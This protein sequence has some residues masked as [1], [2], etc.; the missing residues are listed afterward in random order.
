MSRFARNSVFGTIAGVLGA[1]GSVA[2]NVI[3]ARC[4][5]VEQTGV[6]AF[7]VWTAMLAAAVADLGVQATL[8][9]YLPELLAA[10]REDQA[11]QLG[12]V[13]IR[14]LAISSALIFVAFVIYAQWEQRWRGMP[15]EETAIWGL[16][17]LCCVLQ[18]YA[19]FTYGVLRGLQRFDD[20]ARITAISAVCQ[21][22]GVAV[23]SV[24]FGTLGAL[25]GYCLG[26]VMPAVLSARYRGA[27]RGLSPET[28]A[29]IKRYALY[30]WATTL[31][32]TFVW[33]RS[34]LF[35]LQ[36]STG[37]IAVGL[38]TVSVTLANVAAQAPM[39]LTAGLLPYFAQTHGRRAV[40]EAAEAYAM[41]T[42]VLSFLVFPACCG[43]V[44]L[45][46]TVL[47]LVFGKAFGGAVPAASVLVL[48][49]GVSTATSVGTSLLLAMDRSDV[50]FGVGL[51]LAVLAVI[52]GLTVIPA[53][54]LMGAALTRAVLQI[55]GVI[56]GTVF[57]SRRMHFS[58]PM[59]GFLKIMLAA[60]LSGLATRGCLYL[61]PG[62]SL[63][64]FPI[65]VGIIVYALAV[66]VLGALHPADVSRLRQLCYSLPTT[67]RH[68][69]EIGL[70][71]LS[72]ET[73]APAHL[74]AA[75]NGV[76]VR[77]SLDPNGT[78]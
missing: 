36:R 53:Y 23:G 47:P 71:F 19:G 18:A 60:I 52:A 24:E 51:S 8:A 29:R 26:S 61:A 49:A 56:I 40:A 34:E 66:R 21:L 6:V 17:G 31:S 27:V 1:L 39:L 59:S 73:A 25:G 33:S 12:R 65:V 41:A 4:L 32:S 3:V 37:N 55:L 28:S 11:A 76:A 43:M 38:F 20:V 9:R 62:A 69:S 48:A 5:G 42:R 57:L 64:P 13:L 67:L 50:T 30:V 16:V 44:A 7:A 74:A 54:G 15:A 58:F 10:G 77:S 75:G 22:V 46:P 35:F 72:T 45:L 68:L 2:T 70:R 63:L 78:P 14:P